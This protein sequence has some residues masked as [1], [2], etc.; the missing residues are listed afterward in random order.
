[1]IG[2]AIG[3]SYSYIDLILYDE[4]MF[5]KAFAQIQQQLKSKVDLHYRSFGQEA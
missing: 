4:P 2:G 5:Q 3:K 1:M